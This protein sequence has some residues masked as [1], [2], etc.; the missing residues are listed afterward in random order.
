M[1][2]NKK[3]SVLEKHGFQGLNRWPSKEKM[4]SNNSAEDFFI[5]G[6]AP[7]EPI[8]SKNDSITAFGSCFAGNVSRHL[9]AQ[10]YNVNAHNWKH[11]KS[12]FIR[13][14]EIM[15]HTP[16]LLAQFEWAFSEKPLPNIVIDNR[17]QDVRT[18]HENETVR[19]IIT[20][21]DVF[22]VTFG[23]T[24]A[25]YDKHENIYLWHFVPHKNL[26]SERFVNKKVPFKENYENIESI[27]TLIR[28]K[29]PD[30]KIIFTLS[31]IPLLGTYSGRAIYPANEISK[32]CLRVAIDEVLTKYET[33][34]CLFYFP[35]YELVKYYAK[36]PWKDDNRHITDETV[37][38]M[39]ELFEGH[40]C[41]KNML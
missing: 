6:Y 35:S 4:E 25:W 33:D 34:N 14:D 23:L 11:A 10:G 20:S 16:A 19:D 40:Y 13:I 39:M 22:I 17:K 31:P 41:I 3:I 24:E 8:I 7:V 27:Y 1:I 26:D 15:V 9:R 29:K 21:S 28:S 32:S 38:A 5:H 18:Y 12:D 37:S 36:H 2:Q 30:A